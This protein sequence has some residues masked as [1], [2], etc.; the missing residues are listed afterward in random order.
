MSYEP[1]TVV[2]ISSGACQPIDK[3]QKEQHLDNIFE[4]LRES[5]E[6]QRKLCRQ[7]VRIKPEDAR[8]QQVFRALRIELAAHA[9]A[10]ERF[11]YA[12]ILLDDMGL[13]SSRHALAEHHEIDE[14]VEEMARARGQHDVWLELAKKLSH[15]V[16]HHLREE[17]RKFFQISGKI[18]SDGQKKQLATKYRKDLDRMRTVV[19]P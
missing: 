18:L 5:H 8:A 11:L 16:H 12:P 14:C 3:K 2:P 15:E 13:K 6:T 9:A 19:A 10:E 4:A 17:E 7:L 1:P